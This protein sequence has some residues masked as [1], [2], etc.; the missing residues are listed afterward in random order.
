M[1]NG[2]TMNSRILLLLALVLAGTGCT[3][4]DAGNALPPDEAAARVGELLYTQNLIADPEVNARVRESITAVD[5]DGVP[6][7]SVLPELHTWLERWV[8]KHPDRAGRARLMP[9]QARAAADS[10]SAR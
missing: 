4:N 5:G 1:M 10:A 3:A 9:S 6:A 2:A 8:E 7:D